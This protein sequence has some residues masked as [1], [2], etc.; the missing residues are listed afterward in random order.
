[1]E[2][3]LEQKQPETATEV[4]ETPTAITKEDLDKLKADIKA[5][6]LVE[7][8]E[9]YK[10][11][12]RVVSRVQEENKKLKEQL[13]KS[14]DFS[15][16][17]DLD[18]KQAVS[19]GDNVSLAKISALKMAESEKQ[20]Q[21]AMEIQLAKQQEITEAKRQEIESKIIAAGKNVEDPE[22]DNV[23][24]AWELSAKAD[25]DFSRAE[26]RLEKILKSGKVVKGDEKGK[27]TEAQLRERIEREVLEKNG[28][29]KKEEASPA[30]S[31]KVFTLTSARSGLRAGT[32]R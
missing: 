16:L 27:E 29:L 9:K 15:T 3:N 19:Y 28:L 4:T 8:Q 11:F 12:Q 24:L 31:K 30:G 20:R 13:G 22:F 17:L 26:S 21:L 32:S 10:G 25:G 6:A 23:W 5:E 2:D 1:M 18:E 14:T 7:A